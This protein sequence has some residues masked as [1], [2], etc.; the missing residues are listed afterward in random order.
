M[1]RFNRW[2]RLAVRLVP[3]GLIALALVLGGEAIVYGQLPSLPASSNSTFSTPNGVR[4]HGE[5]E[6]ASIRSSLDWKEL[7]EV[8]SPTIFNRDRVPEGLLLVEVRAEE[9]N[10]RLWRVFYRTYTSQ[11]TPTVTIATLSNQPIIQISDDQSSC[12]IRLVTV[13]GPDADFNGKTLD[14]LAQ[15]WQTI[16]PNEVTRFR[17]LGTPEVI[18]QRI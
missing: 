7:S 18:V 15:E 4:R 5:Y 14:E 12:P 2:L 9:V 8:T 3:L 1:V 6:T 13:T 16:L 11:Q 10:E 17:Q